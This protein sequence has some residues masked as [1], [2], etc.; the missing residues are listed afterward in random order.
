M[1]IIQSICQR[2]L[3]L[4]PFRKF[5]EGTS[6]LPLVSINYCRS[7][8]TKSIEFPGIETKQSIKDL[9]P[10]LDK[11]TIMARVVKKNNKKNWSNS[12]GEGCVF[13]FEV[14]DASGA[15][16]VT[17]FNDEVEKYFDMIQQDNIYYLSNG[18]IQPP[19]WPQYNTV[20]TYL[21]NLTR[22]SNV[23]SVW[24]SI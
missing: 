7:K 14:K 1:S 15:I 4:L 20:S 9:N 8:S 24:M 5:L 3:L 11:Y 6:K 16:K 17:A 2:P 12:R 23:T 18:R 21:K 13:D 19:N 22:K 10:L